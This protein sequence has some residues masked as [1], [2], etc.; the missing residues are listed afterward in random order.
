MATLKD[1]FAIVNLTFYDAEKD[2]EVQHSM[3]FTEVQGYLDVI[4]RL[5]V[6]YSDNDICDL[7]ITMLCD[8]PVYLPPEVIDNIMKDKYN[9]FMLNKED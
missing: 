8:G 5:M 4:N 6:Y 2:K 3:I 1:N 7:H 9:P